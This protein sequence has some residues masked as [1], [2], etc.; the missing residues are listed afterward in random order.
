VLGQRKFTGGFPVGRELFDNVLYSVDVLKFDESA[1][2]V[3]SLYAAFHV[4]L[5]MRFIRV[6]NILSYIRDN[7]G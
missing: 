2:S 4:F 1:R 6:P 7:A 3:A 5:R